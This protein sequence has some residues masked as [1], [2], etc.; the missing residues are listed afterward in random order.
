MMGSRGQQP[1]IIELLERETE[2]NVFFI[3]EVVRALA[4]AAGDLQLIGLATLPQHVFAGGV[5]TIVQRRLDKVPEK[6][7]PLLRLAAAF[8]RELD[9]TV[10]YALAD[11][12]D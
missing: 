1:E 11:G 9:L 3:V 6:Y 12:I 7:W 8:G 2:G 4:E 10:L 5:Q